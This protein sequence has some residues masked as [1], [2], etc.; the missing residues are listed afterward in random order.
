MLATLG[1][2]TRGG[3]CLIHF[4]RSLMKLFKSQQTVMRMDLDSIHRSDSLAMW[5]FVGAVGMWPHMEGELDV[6]L[7]STSQKRVQKQQVDRMGQAHAKASFCSASPR[8]AV[9]FLDSTKIRGSSPKPADQPSNYI[10]ASRW[11]PKG[12]PSM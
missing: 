9:R 2:F 10:R 11:I 1:S 7:L 8:V 5:S 4:R 12:H 3:S 6:Q